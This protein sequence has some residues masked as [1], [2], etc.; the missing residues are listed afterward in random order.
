MGVMVQIEVNPLLVILRKLVY[1]FRTLV[2]QSSNNVVSALVNSLHFN[3]SL[4]FQQWND[5]LFLLN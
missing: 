2:M 4:I 1:G 3:S 5:I